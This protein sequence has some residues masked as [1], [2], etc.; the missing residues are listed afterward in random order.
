MGTKSRSSVLCVLNSVRRRRS[1]FV[2]GTCAIGTIAATLTVVGGAGAATE[3]PRSATLVQKRP[4]HAGETFAT[5]G[6]RRLCLAEGR[7]CRVTKRAAQTR[8][9]QRYGFICVRDTADPTHFVL[10]K[11]RFPSPAP[12]N[13]EVGPT[14]STRPP[15]PGYEGRWLGEAPIWSWPYLQ[16]DPRT[17]IWRLTE[18]DAW[19]E[20]GG[21][22][23]KFV[24]VVSRTMRQTVSLTITSRSGR[25]VPIQA[26]ES[27]PASSLLLDPARP[28]HPD[29]P[30]KPVTHEWG[31]TVFLPAAGCYRAEASWF[32]GS[33]RL[34]FAFGR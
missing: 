23:I 3:R 12:T 34:G 1:A 10:R 19:L 27:A 14:P 18:R 31:S 16:V 6:G 17:S 22:P 13:C 2:K 24:W 4:C 25:V 28:G 33:W 20:R 7:R 15:G 29:V 9:Y 21:W 11:L 26:G 5:V 32:G 8:A 30:E